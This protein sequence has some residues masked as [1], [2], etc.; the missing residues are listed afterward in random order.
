[1]ERE[2]GKI[3]AE[4]FSFF[5]IT[6]RLISHELKNILAIISETA[7]LFEELV[8]LSE[9]G[10]KLESGRLR[11]LGESIEEEI[12]RANAVVG[13]MNRFAHSVDDLVGEVD[14]NRTL[15]LMIGLARFNPLSKS[16]KIRREEGETHGV[17]TCPFFLQN[18][19]HRA[20]EFALEFPGPKRE[21]LMRTDAGEDQGVRIRLSGIAS[22]S[23]GAFPAE[24][25]Q[26]LAHTISVHLSSDSLAG[27]LSLTLP[28]RL[29][30]GSIEALLLNK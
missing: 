10:V 30:D 20:L 12:G 13:L 11:A 17:Y 25:T 19:I 22:E 14:I 4:G 15:D 3:C 28:Q 18:L 1:M 23:V 8:E 2:L 24:D 6:N 26:R 21:I 27:E 7:G 9:S 29:N 5:G 16:V